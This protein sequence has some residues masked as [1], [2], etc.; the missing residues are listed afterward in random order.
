LFIFTEPVQASRRVE[1]AQASLPYCSI[2]PTEPDVVSLS[3]SDIED[4]L[5]FLSLSAARGL[6]S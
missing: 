3:S 4:A 6:T 5:E 1:P 2:R